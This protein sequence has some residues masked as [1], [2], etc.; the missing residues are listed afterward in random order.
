MQSVPINRDIGG[1]GT[2]CGLN[3]SQHQ[4]TGENYFRLRKP[5]NNAG[6]LGTNRKDNTSNSEATAPSARPT[7]EPGAFTYVSSLAPCCRV[8]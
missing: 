2:E 1:G 4:D 6:L 3:P 7:V 8:S 5:G